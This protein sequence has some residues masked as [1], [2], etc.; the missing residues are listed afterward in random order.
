MRRLFLI[1]IFSSSWANASELTTNG[2]GPQYQV[3]AAA[4]AAGPA[5]NISTQNICNGDQGFTVLIDR[6]L[7]TQGGQSIP[8]CEMNL[9]PYFAQLF[10]A[11][12]PKCAKEAALKSGMDVPTSVSVEQLGGYVNRNARNSNQLSRHALGMAMDVS[13][14]TLRYRDFL[15]RESVKQIDLSKQT[16]NQAFYDS[17]R[18]CWDASVAE[19]NGKNCACSVG[20]SLSREPSNELHDDHVHL[21][22]ACPPGGAITCSNQET[23]SNFAKL[24]TH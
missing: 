3:N 10:K 11:F 22:L 16:N 4:I 12:V 9:N 24:F 14:V 20:H 17:F 13:S 6:D 1:I 21:A 15:G 8:S 5:N 18:S 7:L 19:V 2:T 23:M